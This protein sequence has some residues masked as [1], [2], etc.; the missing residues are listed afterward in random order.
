[1]S[2]QYK[3]NTFCFHPKKKICTCRSL[4]LQ[5]CKKV[6]KPVK[7]VFN[8]ILPTLAFLICRYMYSTTDLHLLCYSNVSWLFRYCFRT[9]CTVFN[10]KF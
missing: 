8:T 1:M 7:N 4:C 10:P 3:D 9:F 6:F 5:V 2:E